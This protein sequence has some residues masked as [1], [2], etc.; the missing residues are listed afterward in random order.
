[1]RWYIYRV[2]AIRSS[3][4]RSPSSLART[5]YTYDEKLHIA[6]RFLL[7][8]QLKAN[9]L[10][11][12][13]IVLTEPALLQ[14][15]T[16]Y[17]REAGVRSLERA[18]GSV[19]RYKAVEWAEHNYQDGD[20]LSAYEK[21]VREEDLEEILGIP[22]YDGE[23]ERSPKKGVAYGLVV[24]GLGEGSILPVETCMIPGKGDLRLT[25]SLGEVRSVPSFPSVNATQYPRTNHTGYQGEQLFG[26][27]LGKDARLR[28][29]DHFEPQRRPA[30]G[31]ERGRRAPSLTGWCAEEG[32]SVR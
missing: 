29:T 27:E 15:V 10:D 11:P 1:M 4:Q 18:I 8:K 14:I 12:S 19:V 26:L 22:R 16:G 7:P 6:S 5:G 28:F 32:Q 30:E 17:T 9:G 20:R 21:K 23:K 3:P 24:S 31:S 2:S 25:G 13:H